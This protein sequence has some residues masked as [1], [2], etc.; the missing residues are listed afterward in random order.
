MAEHPKLT[1][2]AAVRLD[3]CSVTMMAGAC[4]RAIH[5]AP[6]YDARPMCI[7]H[8]NDPDK[9]DTE[10]QRH[11]EAIRGEANSKGTYDADTFADFTAFVFPAAYYPLYVFEANCR[12][13]DARFAQ[14]ADFNGA[15]FNRSADFS[16]AT[17]TKDADFSEATFAQ[18]ANFTSA[19]FE[20]GAHFKGAKFE[21]GAFFGAA[22]FAQMA[23]FDRVQFTSGA[24]FHSASFA[25]DPAFVNTERE[26]S[27]K[28][29]L[30]TLGASF[31][32]ATF[33]Q[34]ANFP[35]V[36]FALNADFGNAVFMQSTDFSQS[37][38]C[39]EADFSGAK[40]TQAANFSASAFTESVRF[41]SARFEQNAYF[42]E[43]RFKRDAIFIQAEFMKEAGF[44]NAWFFREA[45]FRYARFLESAEFRG[46]T[47]RGRVFREAELK[48]MGPE[49]IKIAKEFQK[50]MDSDDKRQPGPT[51]SL[52]Q[53]FQ[54]EKVIFYL[55]NFGQALFYNCDV[56]G[57]KFSSVTWRRRKGSRKWMLFEEDVDLN[58][59]AALELKSLPGSPNERDYFLIRETYQQLKKN[60]DDRTDY[61]TAGDF[62]YGEMEMR[63]NDSPWKNKAMR[64]LHQNLRLV[65][66]YKYA[67]QY[68]E[69][70]ARPAFCL[71]G[72]LL[73]FTLLFPWTGLDLAG[74]SSQLTYPHFSDFV[75]AHPYPTGLC[76]AGLFLGYA[77]RTTFGHS[78]MTAISVAGFQKELKYVPSYPWGRALALFELLLTSTLIALFLLAVRRQF[79]R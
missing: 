62:H 1:Q 35:G 52:A 26:S 75:K 77:L 64:R 15:T 25:S 11:F 78:L 36:T 48:G 57:V 38:F 4:S 24:Q 41:H 5:H 34:D 79:K 72:V 67:S 73:F 69:S 68:G 37:T 3:R 13:V 56:S 66:W 45:D 33:K 46:T 18:I 58:H 54:P 6:D 12:F 9:S 23:F 42:Y 32:N 71:A 44:S 50:A 49:N 61:G 17:F 21:Q 63:R 14:N 28:R 27:S 7:M 19:K 55:T 74:A 59:E 16:S 51:F 40:F 70:F 43:T 60:Y 30:P 2:S 20:R 76:R 29:G 47:F 39:D 53:F 31:R 22:D 65:A 8:S 10:F